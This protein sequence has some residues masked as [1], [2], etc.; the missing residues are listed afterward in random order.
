MS[1]VL[2]GENLTAADLEK[3]REEYKFYIKITVD[4]RQELVVVGGEYHADAEQLLLGKYG[5]LQSDIWGG[6]F[7]IEA[8]QFET[9]AIINLRSGVNDSMEI[10]DADLRSRFLE[11]VRSRLANILELL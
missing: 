5:S 8:K 9:N 2:V 3:A 11:L 4:L 10:L 7:N 6:G 1:L